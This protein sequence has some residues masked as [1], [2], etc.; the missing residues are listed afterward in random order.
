MKLAHRQERQVLHYRGGYYLRENNRIGL[1]LHN[2]DEFLDGLGKVDLRL[3]P[4]AIHFYDEASMERGKLVLKE[5][6]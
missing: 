5:G 6:D 1:Y 4:G 2:S 3:E